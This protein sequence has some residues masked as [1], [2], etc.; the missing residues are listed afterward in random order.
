VKHMRL[1][2]ARRSVSTA[3]LLLGA[4]FATAIAVVVAV[5]AGATVPGPNGL[6]AFRADTGSGNQIYTIDPNTLAQVQLT[7]VNG[8]ALQP[9]W[10]ADSS[11]ITFEFDPANPTS[12]DFCNVA[13]M[14]ANGANQVILPLANGD[15]CEAAP[16]FSPD[17]RIFY[18]GFNGK[19]R[20]AI[21]SMSLSGGDR[22]LITTCE[23]RGVTDPEISPDGTML[24]F[25]CFS[26]TG[27]ALFDA[28]INGSHLRQLTSYSLDVGTKEDWSP[29]GDRIMFIS[30]PGEG[31]PNAQINTAT[32]RYDGTGLFWVTNYPAGGTLAF[33]NSYS[34]DGQWIV[35]RLQEGGLY[36]LYKIHPDGSGLQSITSFS[37]F[38]PRGMAWGS[39]S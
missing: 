8:D 33:G 10:S 37:T 27:S 16:S 21:W 6:I 23:G 11:L 38:Q 35:L 18:E 24:A 3:K 31:T 2:E 14:D 36:A 32:I 5:P 30:T 39:A 34:P 29:D 17:G 22:R 26:R 7:N 28:R 9:H 20:D 1:P 25:T 4:V 19:H 13:Y 15:Q 12:N